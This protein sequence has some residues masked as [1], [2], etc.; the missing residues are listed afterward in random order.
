MAAAR[1]SVYSS[2]HDPFVK[3]EGP[4][5]SLTGWESQ[6]DVGGRAHLLVKPLE[7]WSILFTGDYLRSQGTGSRGVDSSGGH[8]RHQLRRRQ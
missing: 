6:D 1:I 5:R 7:Q 8:G 2:N 3:N 4:L